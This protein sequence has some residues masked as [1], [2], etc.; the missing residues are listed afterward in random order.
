MSSLKNLPPPLPGRYYLPSAG[1]FHFYVDLRQGS[2][3]WLL[4]LTFICLLVAYLPLW[5]QV[6]YESGCLLSLQR[7]GSEINYQL[8]YLGFKSERRNH[9]CLF[10]NFLE[11]ANEKQICDTAYQDGEFINCHLV[12]GDFE[13]YLTKFDAQCQSLPAYCNIFQFIFYLGVFLVVIVGISAVLAVLI[14]GGM[15]IVNRCAKQEP[16]T[17]V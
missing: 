4:P 2:V 12:V 7:E 3:L 8:D 13:P 14:L 15:K 5:Q 10:F 6:T 16:V 11:I 9:S 1:S 17:E